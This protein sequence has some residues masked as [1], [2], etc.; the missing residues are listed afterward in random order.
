MIVPGVSHARAEGAPAT[1][2]VPGNP[3]R[4]TRAGIP[5]PS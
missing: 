1:A 2:G 5:A 3:P 4:D